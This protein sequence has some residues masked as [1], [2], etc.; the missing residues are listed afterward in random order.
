[1]QCG[2]DIRLPAASILKWLTALV[3]DVVPDVA[4]MMRAVLGSRPACTS[5]RAYR[6]ECT[7]F[8]VPMHPANVRLPAASIVKW[9]IALPW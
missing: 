1:M 3:P 6:W 5:S 8:P 7:R 4:Y 9:L 2:M